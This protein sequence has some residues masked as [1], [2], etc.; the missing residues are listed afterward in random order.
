[1][2]RISDFRMGGV[3]RRN[4]LMFRQLCGDE[5]LRN[6]VIATTMWSEVTPERGAA[7]ELELRTRE[8]FFKPLLDRRATMLRHE[9]TL[10]SAHAILHH[11]IDNRP[12]P[13]RIQCEL[14]DEGKDITE[15]GAG[16]ELDR[17]LATLRQKHMKELEEVQAEMKA[18]LQAKDSE[19]R[20]ELEKVQQDLTRNV[21]KIENDR[22]RLS[23]E[24]AAE[25]AQADAEIL[26]IMNV[27]EGER[28]ARE[29]KERQITEMIRV[30]EADRAANAGE[31]ARLN[32]Q[33]AEIQS[34]P[35]RKRRGFWRKVRR[36]LSM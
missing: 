21:Q 14:V 25:R 5:T 15:T 30:M 3:S 35:P 22:E 17:E 33:L 12:E 29:E 9:N 32:R 2:H 8:A 36:A 20:K 6:V 11:I 26:R 18:A 13:L 7:R 24:Y 28:V 4:L 10:A 27:L 23:R 1:M 31:I 19:T 16:Q 34:P